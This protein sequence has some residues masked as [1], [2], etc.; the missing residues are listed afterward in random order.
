MGMFGNLM[1]AVKNGGKKQTPAVKSQC[2]HQLRPWPISTPK[3]EVV[4]SG[5]SERTIYGY[6]STPLGNVGSGQIVTVELFRGDGFMTSTATGYRKETGDLDCIALY[7]GAPIGFMTFPAD[8]LKQSAEL[9]YA[10]KAKAKCHGMLEGYVGIKSMTALVPDRFYLHDW[11]PGA[12]DDRPM[13]DREYVFHYNEYDAED[14][15]N[16][17]TRNKWTFKGAR[18]EMIPT[19]PKSSAKPH[20][21]VYSHDGML[22]SE[23]AAKNSYYSNLLKFMESYKSFEVKAVRKEGDDG[24]AYYSIDIIG[25]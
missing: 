10:V 23:V 12:E 19:P 8:K 18:I 17:A 16:L 24:M 25:K 3:Y 20:I 13:R 22:L 5:D 7:D 11:I 1:K 21:G 4:I 15:A 6:D 2:F 14:Y 9:G